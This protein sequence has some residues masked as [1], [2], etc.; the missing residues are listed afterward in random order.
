MQDSGVDEVAMPFRLWYY[1]ARLV[2]P[3]LFAAVFFGAI[4]PKPWIVQFVFNPALYVLIALCCIGGVMGILMAFGRL[5]M[6]CPFCARYGLVGGN[7]TDGLW[8]KCNDCGFVHG[9]GLLKMRF[10]RDRE[11]QNDEA[12]RNAAE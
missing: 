5:R 10:V 6:R 3:I 11:N 7:K 2:A 1:G 12:S 9:A 8:L 4:F